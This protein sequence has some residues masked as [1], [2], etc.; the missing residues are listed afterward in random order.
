MDA[1]DR[2]EIHELASRYGD[3]IDHRDWPGLGRVFTEDAVF[4]NPTLPGQD[5]VG[6]EAIRKVM[7]NAGSRHPLSHHITNIYVDDLED[8]MAELHCR[9]IHHLD[10]GRTRSGEYV[11]RVV[12]TPE[13]WRIKVRSFQY[14]VRP[15]EDA[16]TDVSRPPRKD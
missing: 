9:I 14:R 16:A 8:G 13:G 1:A 4:T 15:A 2:I 6:L 12:K 11:D 10:D 3:L 5:L 7:R